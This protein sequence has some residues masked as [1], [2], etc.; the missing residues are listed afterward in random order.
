MD[1]ILEYARERIEKGSKSFA[2]AAKLFDPTRRDSAML[3][4][5][6]CRHC[7]DVVDDQVLGFADP[8]ARSED[9]GATR[10]RLAEL[11]RKTRDALRGTAT[12][13]AFQALARVAAECSMP[14]RHPLDHL[15]GFAMDVDERRYETLEDTLDYCYHVAGVVGVM[16]AIVMDVRDRPTLERA[17][18]L[19][20]AFQLTNIA[21]DVADDAALGRIYLPAGWLALEGV[22]A[23]PA[24]IMAEENRP[25]VAKVTARLLDV[26]DGYYESAGAGI[27]RLPYRAAM[28]ITA[29]R[30]V[31][32]TIGSVV[33]ARGTDAV[34]HRAIVS[35]PSKLAR[36]A[37]APVVAGWLKMADAL[38][39]ERPRNGLWTKPGLG[40]D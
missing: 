36:L 18:D 20:I 12:E 1:P 25:S 26:A 32:R 14:E 11:E 8:D 13:P 24:A 29:A 17:S 37:T 7:D 39:P 33:R 6:W 22:E 21:R 10:D 2:G 16:M 4:Y 19:G 15:A 3:L 35:R 23:E 40:L 38:T 28:A 31:Y 30:S 5:A 9:R 34:G 27:A